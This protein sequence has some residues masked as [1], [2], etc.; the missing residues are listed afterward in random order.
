M[1][2]IGKLSYL[3]LGWKSNILETKEYE[4]TDE[5]KVPVIKNWL[6]TK[7]LVTHKNIHK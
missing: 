1:P 4:L 6:G 5:E 7:W 2:R 3:T